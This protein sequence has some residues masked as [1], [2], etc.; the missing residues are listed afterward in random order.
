LVL[1]AGAVI[2]LAA[3]R[4]AFRA[5]RQVR[6]LHGFAH[7]SRREWMLGV[8]ILEHVLERVGSFV[9]RARPMP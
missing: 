6:V 4:E 1:F 9:T 7:P 2:A 8:A 5:L 3:I